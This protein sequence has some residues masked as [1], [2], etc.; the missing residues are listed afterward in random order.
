M[1]NI[2]YR[3][4]NPRLDNGELTLRQVRDTL[5]ANDPEDISKIVKLL[6]NPKSPIALKGAVTLDRHDAIHIVLGRGLLP[7]DEAFVIGF[8]MGTS[9]NIRKWE[10]FLFKAASMYIYPKIYR[11]NRTHMK[12]FDLGLQAGKKSKVKKIY[13]FPFENCDHMKLAELRKIVGVDINELK[14]YFRKE[15]EVLPNTRCSKRLD[16]S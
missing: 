14:N 12:A 5:P 6:E 7:Q 13:E 2:S 15:I 3:D 16:V 4:W 8:T 9:K 1:K 10:E 11:F